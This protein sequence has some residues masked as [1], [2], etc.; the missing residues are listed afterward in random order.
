MEAWER[1]KVAHERVAADVRRRA[2]C[3]F[4]DVI[5]REA[6]E[7]REERLFL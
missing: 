3:R 7:P 6:H 5:R 4:G 1:I 2:L